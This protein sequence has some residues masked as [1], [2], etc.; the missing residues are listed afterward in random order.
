MCP[1]VC[2]YVCPYVCVRLHVDGLCVTAIECVLLAIECVL[3]AIECVPY[4]CP[5]QC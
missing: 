4:V 2:P 1:S 5:S 3:L